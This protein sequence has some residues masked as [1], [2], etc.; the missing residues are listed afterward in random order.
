MAQLALAFDIL[1]KDRASQTFTNVGRSADD[2]GRKV[3]GF[4]SKFGS[5]GAS[6]KT[7]LAGMGAGAVV[8]GKQAVDAFRESEVAQSQL[9][10]AFS[11][12]PQL[13]GGSV[14]ALQKLNEELAKKT[15][16]DDD[17]TASGQAVLA[18][19]GLTEDQLAKVTPLLQDYAQRTGKD[20]PTAAEDLGKAVKGQGRA[21]KGIGLDLKDTG[22]A[23]G[24]FEALMTG[25][26]EK[27][28]GFA[29]TAG[30]TTSGKLAILGNQFGELQEKV[31]EKLIPALLKLSDVGLKV[32]D[33]LSNLSPQMK[34]A[35][36]AVASL[37]GGVYVIIQA[38]KAWTAVQAAFNIVMSA[39]PI[40]LA[41]IA[42][43]GLVAAVVVAYQKVEWFRNLV[44]GAFKVI[45]G[46]ISGVFNWVKANWPTLLAILTG[47]IGLAVLAITQHWDTIKNGVTAVKDWIGEKFDEVVT[48]VTGL[49]GRISTAAS[50]M[51]NGIKDGFKGALNSIIRLWNG[52]KFPE[53][54]IGGSDPLGR[55]G[56][57]LPEATIGGWEL[58]KIPLIAHSGGHV[59]A[60]GLKPLRSD[61]VFSKLQVGE[62]VLPRGVG[63]GGGAP[64]YNVTINAPSEALRRPSDITRE[65]RTAHFLMNGW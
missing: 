35:I 1:A 6:M 45:H 20:L 22:S 23:A 63:P 32:V 56:P 2:A 50:G 47:P 51:W 31:G 18:Q 37:A 48:F 60:A 61:E 4:G 29:E 40:V 9:S 12:F 41:G 59:T 15:T 16:F 64:T 38:Q 33:F 53:V 19:F 54:T 11:K 55:F 21:L 5:L 43:A 28:G 52:F 14:G 42:I 62:T 36:G 7:A 24:N 13:A 44:D 8:F 26:T 10:E 65:L 49:P 34:V 39:N 17:A 46:A 25:L 30:G 58:P 27:V 3:G 57:S